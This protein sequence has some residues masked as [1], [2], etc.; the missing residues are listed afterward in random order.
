MITTKG[1]CLGVLFAGL[2]MTVCFSGELTLVDPASD[3]RLAIWKEADGQTALKAEEVARLD[4]WAKLAE[5][6]GG[7][8]VKGAISVKNLVEVDS[9]VIGT[10]RTRL[11]KMTT[12]DMVYYG[13]GVVQ[14]KVSAK[15]SDLVESIESYL[16]ESKSNGATVNKDLF[17]K[18]NVDAND[19]VVTMWGN[20]ALENSEGVLVVQAIRAAELSALEQMVAMLEGVQIGRE[21]IVKDLVLASD[22]IKACIDDAAKGVQYVEYRVLQKTVEVDAMVK[23]ISIIERIERVYEDVYT[24][25]LCTGCPILEKREFQQVV[26]REESRTHNATGKA[27]IKEYA[28]S[29]DLRSGSITPSVGGKT[30]ITRETISDSNDRVVRREIVEEKVVREVIGVN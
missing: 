16:K 2:A 27:A 25:D 24:T 30:E 4:A 18:Y 6:I 15:L 13:N 19:R 14:C 3:K 8:E 28:S 5:F 11:S 22:R 12:E 23:F 10:L 21:T 26:Q 1:L 20:G 9:K 7:M 17:R 29:D